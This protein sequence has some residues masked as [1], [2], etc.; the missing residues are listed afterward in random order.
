MRIPIVLVILAA[1]FATP[2]QSS[3]RGNTADF[4]ED[5]VD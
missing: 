2:N 5:S 1:C 4:S 3:E